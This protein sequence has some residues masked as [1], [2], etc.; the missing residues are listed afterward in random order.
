MDPAAAGVLM[1]IVY[2]LP[3]LE[4]PQQGGQGTDVDRGGGDGQ[5]VIRDPGQLVEQ[6]SDG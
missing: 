6:G 2:P 4:G 5:Q 3:L 1:Q